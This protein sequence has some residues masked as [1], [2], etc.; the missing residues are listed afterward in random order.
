MKKILIISAVF[1]PE[2][3]TSALMNYDLAVSLSERYEVTV[4]R[5]RP[6]RP[7]GTAYGDVKD[8]FSFRCI[9][10]DTYT[11]PQSR[12]VGRFRESI[13]FGHACVRYIKEHVGEIDF[14]YNASWQ[15]FGYAIVA[16]ACRMAGVPYMV[17]IQDIYPECLFTGKRIPSFVVSVLAGI[18]KPIDRYYQAGAFRV[19]TISEEMASYLSQTRGVERNRYLVVD[20]WQNDEDFDGVQEISMPEHLVFGYVGSINAHSNTELI[21]RAFHKAGIK[22]SELRIYGGGNHKEQ[23]AA[24]AKEL[25]ADNVSFDRV[26][27]KQVPEAQ[28]GVSVLVLALP[29]GNGN[30]CLPSKMTS[31]MLSGRP[32]LAS[33]DADSSTARYIKEASC[34]VSV[35]P[36]N[37]D[38][39]AD[40]FRYFSKLTNSELLQMGRNSRSFAD[41]KLTRK[42]NLGAVVSCI[43]EALKEK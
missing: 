39:M 43:D 8:D 11:C 26:D 28:A 36:D 38:A 19:R 32:V 13:S 34:G 35:S 9:T 4:V 2:P 25:G 14:V 12:L 7:Q 40:G 18:L 21:I 20:N 29:A 1:P 16:R 30:L 42:V 27:K 6:T 41:K 37:V 15:L 31:Y 24:L 22:D 10:L 23:C 5:P 3:V 33:V 17:P